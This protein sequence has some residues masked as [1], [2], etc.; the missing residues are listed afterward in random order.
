LLLVEREVGG[1]EV[2]GGD[3]GCEEL[4][5]CS[6]RG[7]HGNGREE[8]DWGRSQEGDRGRGGQARCTRRECFLLFLLPF[9][10]SKDEGT[11][12]FKGLP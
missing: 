4:C 8:E 11:R 7:S 12:I 6:G 5:A 1:L 9:S 2:V 10:L 3:H